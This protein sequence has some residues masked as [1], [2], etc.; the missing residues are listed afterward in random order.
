[1]ICWYLEVGITIPGFCCYLANVAKSHK[2]AVIN[3]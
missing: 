3:M 1:M 2:K